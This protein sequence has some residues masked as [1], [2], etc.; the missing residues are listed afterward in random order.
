MLLSADVPYL[1]NE[2]D[3][4]IKVGAELVYLD[5]LS[6]QTGYNF[7]SDAQGLTFGAGVLW[8]KINVNY[9]LGLTEGLSDV[10]RITI[11]YRFGET[12]LVPAEDKTKVDFKRI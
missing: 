2:K 9:G 11:G 5:S 4:I 6:L 1:V 12:I 10:H 3:A 8:G 7:N